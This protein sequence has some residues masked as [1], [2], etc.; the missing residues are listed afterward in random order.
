MK[1]G[2]RSVEL[3]TVCEKITDGSHNPA[4]GVD[5]SDFLMLSSKN[6]FEDR[7]T[8]DKPRY[9]TQ[10][11]FEAEDRR[12][13]VQAGDVLL[14]I[15]GTVGRSAVVGSELPRFTLQ[16]SVAVLKPN[17]AFVDSRFLMF[18]LQSI[19]KDLLGGARGVAQ[20]G[21]YLSSLRTM[22]ITLPPLEEQRRMVA[23]LDEAFEGLDRAKANAEANLANAQELFE[24]ALRDSFSVLPPD[25]TRAKL[26]SIT[27]KIGSGATPKGGKEAYKATGISLIR[28]LNVYDREFKAAKLAFIDD[29]Q[30]EKLKN[31]EVEP[32]DVLLNITG[33][34]VARCCVAPEA[35][36]PARVNQHVSIIRA[37]PEQLRS[38][39]LCLFLTSD[40][41][42]RLLLQI[43]SEGGATRQ[44][45]TKKQIEALEVAYP[46]LSEQDRIIGR[47]SDLQRQSIEVLNSYQAKIEAINE[48]R[49]SLLAKAFA[50]ELT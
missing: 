34:S 30:A 32:D 15:V 19:L 41:V 28:S 17:R 11:D 7:I 6:V 50:G 24:A 21:V 3:G 43:S 46:V 22:L 31:V 48:L 23:I 39:F 29:Q 38:Q 45:I 33:A 35:T 14:T 12:T 9:L 47:L 20:K 16:R 26:A 49:Q 27:T 25:W 42:K 18:A 1:A 2:W 10:S 8:L 4:K 40:P 13:S 37:V 44:A 5:F 36:L